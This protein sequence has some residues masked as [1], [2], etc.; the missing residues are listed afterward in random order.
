MHKPVI[1]HRPDAL[2]RSP[3]LKRGVKTDNTNQTLLNPQLFVKKATGRG[4]IKL[5]DKQLRQKLKEVTAQD[6]VTEAME[7]IKASG[8]RAL[9]KGL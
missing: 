4:T 3:D 7:V 8:P 5:L 9:A 6:K 1:T 2:S